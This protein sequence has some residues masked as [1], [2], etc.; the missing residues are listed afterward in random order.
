MGLLELLERRERRCPSVTCSGVS[1]V[2]NLSS[3][4]FKT[5]RHVSQI[6]DGRRRWLG[7]SLRVSMDKGRTVQRSSKQITKNKR[8]IQPWLVAL[9]VNAPH[10]SPLRLHS[11]PGSDNSYA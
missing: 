7:C 11:W 3:L 5:I 9:I 6:C 2:R 10:L 8:Q 1:A 4:T